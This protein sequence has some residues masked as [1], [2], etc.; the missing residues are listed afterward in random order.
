MFLL[1]WCF[2]F[3]RISQNYAKI[4][5]YSHKVWTNFAKS[6]SRELFEALQLFSSV[7]FPRPN[8][9]TH[10]LYGILINANFK[11]NCS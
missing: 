11:R 3:H 5:K 9:N 7:V 2:F 4:N 1:C 10:D 8:K 6:R